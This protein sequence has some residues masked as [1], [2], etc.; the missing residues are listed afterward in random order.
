MG[1][2]GRF[3]GASHSP[4][5]FICQMIQLT[6]SDRI[7]KERKLK[8][9]IP[10]A[11]NTK[12]LNAILANQI[13]PFVKRVK[14]DLF[15]KYNDD[16]TFINQLNHINKR[17]DKNFNIKSIWC[18]EAFWKDLTFIFDVKLSQ[19]GNEMN[20]Y[21]H[22]KDKKWQTHSKYHSWWQKFKVFPLRSGT[23]PKMS[24]FISTN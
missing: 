14:W 17:K 13:Q 8:T 18:R 12:I 1:E 19:N 24:T 16:S 6:K 5:T 2:V 22:R 3:L 4:S 10:D 9:H 21:L 20:I 23:R 15:Q 7:L 11:H